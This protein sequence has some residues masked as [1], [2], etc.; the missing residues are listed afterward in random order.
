MTMPRP[1]SMTT[2]MTASGSGSGQQ[3][4]VP[5]RRGTSVEGV[6]VGEREASPVGGVGDMRLEDVV[7]AVA[8]RV[9]TVGI[10][11][12]LC[13]DMGVGGKSQIFFFGGG[14]NVGG[15]YWG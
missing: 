14:S 8:A 6:G 15:V 1:I 13:E 11:V 5:R 12:I 9:T 10:D 4:Q 3:Q 2:T 7:T